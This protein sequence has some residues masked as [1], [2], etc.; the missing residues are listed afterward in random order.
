MSRS[1]TITASRSIV[2]DA[3]PFTR[4]YPSDLSRNRSLQDRNVTNLIQ[5]IDDVLRD[6]SAVRRAPVRIGRSET[7][8][9]QAKL[10]RAARR[11][12]AAR[13][14]G[15]A[16]P[17]RKEFVRARALLQSIDIP[18]RWRLG[19]FPDGEGG[20]EMRFYDEQSRTHISLIIA[21]E[22][23]SGSFAS[24]GDLETSEFRSVRD[25]AAWIESRL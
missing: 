17:S 21:D 1:S 20:L 22:E 10:H 18:P 15:I 25:L 6:S 5:V 14:K 9:W 2:V 4:V 11:I 3:P 7:A 13:G 24:G 19:I 8:L 12:Q 16:L 23:L